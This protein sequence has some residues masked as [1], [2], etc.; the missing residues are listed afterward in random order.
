MLGLWDPARPSAPGAGPRPGLMSPVGR[1][2]GPEEPSGVP[3]HGSCPLPGRGRDTSLLVL[4]AAQED[5]LRL[6]STGRGSLGS[7][8]PGPGTH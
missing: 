8:G 4:T 7:G 5:R 1:R 2:G 6:A 3:G